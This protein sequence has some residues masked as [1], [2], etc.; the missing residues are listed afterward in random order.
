MVRSILAIVAG[1]LVIGALAVGTDVALARS[2]PT[3]FDANNVTTHPGFLALKLV[4]VAI[5]ATFGCWLAAR[6]APSRPMM[7]ALILGA[8]GLVFNIVGSVMSWELQP[9]LWFH[10]IGLGSTMIWAWL[11]GL[12]RERQIENA[13]PARPSTIATA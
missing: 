13:T 8:L 10:A 5:Y 11:G 7:H 3:H 2:F 12:I 9:I 4:Y 1:F 6:L